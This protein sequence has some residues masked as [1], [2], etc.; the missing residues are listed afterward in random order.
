MTTITTIDR[1]AVLVDG[2]F[3]E[4]TA[5]FVIPRANYLT[6]SNAATITQNI[7]TE[8]SDVY[9]ISGTN[10]FTPVT[11]RHLV[12]D[13]KDTILNQIQKHV[14]V[15]QKSAV[16]EETK[17]VLNEYLPQGN[18]FE[19]IAVTL[20]EP[21]AVIN[22]TRLVIQTVFDKLSDYQTNMSVADPFNENNKWNEVRIHCQPTRSTDIKFTTDTA[23]AL[24]L[25]SR[26]FTDPVVTHV[27]DTNA[28]TITEAKKFTEQTF[29]HILTTTNVIDGEFEPI[30]TTTFAGELQATI[31]HGVI[32][33]DI[34][35]SSSRQQPRRKD[36]RDTARKLIESIPDTE[37]CR[38]L[39]DTIYT[40]GVII[41][42]TRMTLQ[43]GYDKLSNEPTT[44]RVSN[45]FAIS[46]HKWDETRIEQPTTEDPFKTTPTETDTEI[47][48]AQTDQIGEEFTFDQATEG[49]RVTLSTIETTTFKITNITRGSDLPV[50]GDNNFKADAYALITPSSDI[51]T[52]RYIVKNKI[53]E[54]S[55]WK[56][57]S[58]GGANKNS[59][60]TDVSIQLQKSN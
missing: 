59:A 58:N 54:L 19:N 11:T 35:E 38:S 25:H 4:E 3:F 60:E 48:E 31:K 1:E 12:K 5:L 18:D 15:T 29:N 22:A 14:A 44:M 57:G 32:H 51:V 7:F 55:V 41:H 43:T 52:S 26:Y 49:D 33:S 37:T 24:T 50:S 34:F 23:H 47:N 53:G 13:L 17:T 2:T 46:D 28:L 56:T 42:I 16:K 39:P 45:P 36:Q 20:P 27:P 9:D 30:Q 40:P 10:D 6:A 8:I 21:G